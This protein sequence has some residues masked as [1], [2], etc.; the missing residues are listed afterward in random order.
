MV[1]IPANPQPLAE[2]IDKLERENRNLLAR[3]EK[4]EKRGGSIFFEVVRMALLLIFA[5][6]V[7]HLIGLLPPGLERLNVLANTVDAQTLKAG[8][9]DINELS[10]RDGQGAERARLAMQDAEPSLTFFDPQGRLN[11]QV[12]PKNKP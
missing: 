6:L 10:L 2:R 12:P 1:E 7:L 8:R 3:L 11:S 9:L 4:L 5:A